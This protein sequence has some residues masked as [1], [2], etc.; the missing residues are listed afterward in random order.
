VW[1]KDN[2]QHLTLFF[3]V[4]VFLQ[5]F[6][7]LNARKLKKEEINVFEN[8]FDNY[9]FIIIVIGIFVAQLFIVECGGYTFQLTPLTL[10]QH[11]DCIIIGA[12]CVVWN[13]ICKIFIPESFMNSIQ[14]LKD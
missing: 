10:S 2:A 5:I 8:I 6:N 4:F 11:I 12:T 7:F 3:D 14:L 9:L 1:N 13:A